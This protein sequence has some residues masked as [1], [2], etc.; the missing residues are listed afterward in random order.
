MA[1]LAEMASDTK[2]ES[3]TFLYIWLKH[4]SYR[5]CLNVAFPREAV[6]TQTV[7][8]ALPARFLLLFVF[9]F[10]VPCDH[11]ILFIWTLRWEL[12]G[13]RPVS[14]G[15]G[16]CL[17][18]GE[19]MLWALC[20]QCYVPGLYGYRSVLGLCG[21]LEGPELWVQSRYVLECHT[22]SFLSELPVYKKKSLLL[23]V[24]SCCGWKHVDATYRFQYGSERW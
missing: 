16:A 12:Y 18:R 9:T 22:T 1:N 5:R 11:V 13:R 8:G 19:E 24:N 3:N 21:G 14:G 2:S 10:P 6:Y 7:K 23:W 15:Y 20:A 4:Y 17:P